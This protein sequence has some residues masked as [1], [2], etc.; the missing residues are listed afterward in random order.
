MELNSRI[1]AFDFIE[2]KTDKIETIIHKTESK[3]IDDAIQNLLNVI[4]DLAELKEITISIVF[5]DAALQ[6]PC[7]TTVFKK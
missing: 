2:I 6:P 1:S 7:C 4:K 3:K 5:H